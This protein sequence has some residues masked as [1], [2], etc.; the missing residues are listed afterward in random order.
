[1]KVFD[2]DLHEARKGMGKFPQTMINVRISSKDGWDDNASIHRAVEDAES[3]LGKNGRVLLRPSG[4]E[5]LI[6]VMVEGRDESQV[7]KLAGNI[8]EVVAR[9][10]SGKAV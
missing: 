6:R 10:M 4:T 2:E 5:P 9:E 8:A 1:L 7:A 3:E